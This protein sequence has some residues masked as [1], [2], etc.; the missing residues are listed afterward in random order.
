MFE[1][2]A[3]HGTVLPKSASAL[4]V[5]GEGKLSLLIPEEPGDQEICVMAQLLAAVAIKS[6]DPE[7]VDEM[8]A[9]F[10]DSCVN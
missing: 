8:L 9:T 3:D 10:E 6:L 1:I 2:N 7:W 5:D 4:V